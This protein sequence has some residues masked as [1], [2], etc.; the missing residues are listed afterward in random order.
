MAFFRFFAKLMNTDIAA[1]PVSSLHEGQYFDLGTH[2]LSEQEI[3]DFATAFDPLDF[4]TSVE[5][6]EQSHFGELV[7]SGP[8]IFTFVHK[9]EWIPRFGLSVLAGLELTDWKFIGPTRA[10]TSIRA[11]VTVKKYRPN[12]ERGHVVITWYYEFNQENG[13]PVQC[14]DMTVLHKLA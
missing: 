4:H 12:Q 6:A 3:I 14:L 1:I 5:A 9:R 2:A 10:N 11:S 8:H 7:A 13:E